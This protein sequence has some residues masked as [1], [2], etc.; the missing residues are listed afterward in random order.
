MAWMELIKVR[1]RSTTLWSGS[2]CPK[3]FE[4]V[5]GLDGVDEGEEEVNHPL[6]WVGV[7]CFGEV[8]TVGGVGLVVH[9]QPG[10]HIL[11]RP[12]LGSSLASQVPFLNLLKIFFAIMVIAKSS[13]RECSLLHKHMVRSH[14]GL[15]HIVAHR[16]VIIVSEGCNHLLNLGWH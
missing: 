12:N 11:G 6:V 9:E 15:G 5:D 10:L 13:L 8:V 2:E 4:V 16:L 3:R 1:R 14:H 7:S